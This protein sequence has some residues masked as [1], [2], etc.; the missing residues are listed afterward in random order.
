MDQ[1]TAE[2]KIGEQ[3]GDHKGVF[4]VMPTGYTKVSNSSDKLEIK[5][6]CD[7]WSLDNAFDRVWLPSVSPITYTISTCSVCK[8]LEVTQLKVDV[9]PDIE[10]DWTTSIDFG[11]LEFIPGKGSVTYS[12]LAFGEKNNVT[13]TYDGKPHDLKEKYKTY[14]QEPLE[15]FKKVCETVSTVLEIINNPKDALTRLGHN[16]KKPAPKD[17]SDNKD[18]ND[19]KLEIT[20]PNLEFSYTSSLK[21][22]KQHDLV[23]NEYELKVTAKP[24]V[25]IY[26]KVDVVNSIISAASTAAP[27]AGALLEFAKER[28]EQPIKEG[29]NTGLRGELDIIFEIKSDIS[30]TKGLVKGTYNKNGNKVTSDPVEGKFSLPATLEGKVRAEA[31][32]FSISFELH[33]EITGKTEWAGDFEIGSDDTGIYFSH[34]VE[35]QGVDITMSK[36]EELKMEMESDIEQSDNN[37]D[38]FAVEVTVETE[39]GSDSIKAEDGKVEAKTTDKNEQSWSWLKPKREGEKPTTPNEMVTYYLLKH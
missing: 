25:G 24:L 7:T 15:G 9:Y 3:C 19:S 17:G 32:W 22:N 37:Y 38:D 28:I 31:K 18:G 12:D 10:W 8:P 26:I 5:L 14:V 11:K 27:I 30:I 2:F 29:A 4:K 35:F 39:S 21:E 1:V 6:P 33:Y 34:N 13:L 23:D 36:Y 20:W 16:T